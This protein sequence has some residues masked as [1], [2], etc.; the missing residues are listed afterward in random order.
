M[1]RKGRGGGGEGVRS[2]DSCCVT[3]NV[4]VVYEDSA[5]KKAFIL[6]LQYPFRYFISPTV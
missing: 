2:R 3:F 5:S 6:P 1:E 4:Y